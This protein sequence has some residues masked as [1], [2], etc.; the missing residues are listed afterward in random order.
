[1]GQQC[2]ALDADVTIGYNLPIVT[3]P[4]YMIKSFYVV[5]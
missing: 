2:R 5:E 4:A 1:M 3:T